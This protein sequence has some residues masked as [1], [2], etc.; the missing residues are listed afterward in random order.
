MMRGQL[1]LKL[2][3]TD[4]HNACTQHPYNLCCPG[5][6]RTVLVQTTALHRG[7]PFGHFMQNAV[8]DMIHAGPLSTCLSTV[9]LNSFSS[10]RGSSQP[11]M[12]LSEKWHVMYLNYWPVAAGLGVHPKP[13]RGHLLRGAGAVASDLLH[14]AVPDV[15]S[16]SVEQAVC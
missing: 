12:E 1:T 11:G 5:G 14:G 9:L 10:T 13:G 3:H 6:N 4:V 2:I 8:A 16:P 7:L 15:G